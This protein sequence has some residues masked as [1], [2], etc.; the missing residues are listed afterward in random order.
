M[1]YEG[2]I[3]KKKKPKHPYSF[4]IVVKPA[5]E[6]DNFAIVYLKWIWDAEQAHDW[7]PRLCLP[8]IRDFLI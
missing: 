6:K 7:E 1:L 4:T 2:L 5:Q 8:F 3:W